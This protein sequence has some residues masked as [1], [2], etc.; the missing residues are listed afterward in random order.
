MY[1][2]VQVIKHHLWTSQVLVQMMH[3]FRGGYAT[4]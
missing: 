4:T 3:M 2:G 1:F